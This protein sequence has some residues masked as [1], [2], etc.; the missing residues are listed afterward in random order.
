M[1]TSPFDAI[2]AVGQSV[3]TS[4]L[5]EVIGFEGR[6]SGDYISAAD[7]SRPYQE[8]I[9]IVAMTPGIGDVTDGPKSQSQRT[10]QRS[11][12]WMSATDFSALTWDPKRGD[13]VVL[14]PHVEDEK[15]LVISAVLPL[16][17]GDVQIVLGEG[18]K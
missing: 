5:G 14:S 13:I 15:R 17:H 6:I 18:E 3:I 8:A 16:T 10:Y 4:H 2:D 1:V 7:P 12:L 11:E 9:A